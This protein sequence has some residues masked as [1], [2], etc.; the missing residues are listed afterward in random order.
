MRTMRATALVAIL[1]GALLAP[2]A[3]AAPAGS[4]TVVFLTRTTNAPSVLEAK[5]SAGTDGRS[6]SAVG[7]WSL[8]GRG[9]AL[10]GGMAVT[11]GGYQAPETNPAGGPIGCVT[12]PVK[13][14]PVCESRVGG[15]VFGTFRLE[16]AGSAGPRKL[17][18]AFAGDPRLFK[19][20]LTSASRGWTL[21]R[22]ARGVRLKRT[23]DSQGTYVVSSSEGVERF[24][25]ATLPGG[26]RGSLAVAALPCR[27]F[28]GGASTGTGEAVLEGGDEPQ[29]LSCPGGPVQAI[30][31][32]RARTAWTLRGPVIGVTASGIQ[33][34]GAVGAVSSSSQDVRLLVVD[35]PF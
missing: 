24:E 31:Q 28:P 18:I 23:Q 10:E 5:Y 2:A 4:G 30:D 35:G 27:T 17:V 20:S 13:P 9:Q 32:S 19:I 14:A 16:T 11:S 33:A 25:E 21:A 26:S 15:V 3:A 34:T 6:S 12:L 22:S 29:P 7:F 1:T 8:D